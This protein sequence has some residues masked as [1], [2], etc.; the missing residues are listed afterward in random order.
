MNAKKIES[1]IDNYDMDVLFISQCN[2]D[3]D[4]K[5]TDD[6]VI[7][8]RVFEQLGRNYKKRCVLIEDELTLKETLSIYRNIEHLF[9][10][11]R[12]GF[13]LA[14]TQG[15]TASLICQEINTTI[16]K[17]TVNL[18]SLYLGKHSDFN[19]PKIDITKVHALLEEK[20]HSAFNIKISLKILYVTTQCKIINEIV[21][22]IFKSNLFHQIM[23][24][25]DAIFVNYRSRVRS[26]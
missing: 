25:L 19:I 21:F 2:Y 12:H 1:L 13:I 23:E 15:T 9:T 17:E 8:K 6:R 14:L 11:R 10:Y 16:V 26:L 4:S 3:V 22:L 7:N 20:M 18:D 24:L 5:I